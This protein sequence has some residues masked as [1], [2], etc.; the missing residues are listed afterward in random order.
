MISEVERIIHAMMDDA[1][2]LLAAV[3]EERDTITLDKAKEYSRSLKQIDALLGSCRLY[4]T[5]EGFPVSA[6][7]ED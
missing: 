1:E 6:E 2:E 7:K 3:K 4:L 5:T